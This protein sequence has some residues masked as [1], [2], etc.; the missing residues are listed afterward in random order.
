MAMSTK[1]IPVIW[2]L[3]EWWTPKDIEENLKMRNM[4]NMNVETVSNAMRHATR[5][6]FVC[7]AQKDLY[8]PAASSTVIFVG[9]PKPVR[10]QE[11]A[12]MSQHSVSFSEIQPFVFLYIGRKIRQ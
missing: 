10:L 4:S 1:K 12:L 7:A 8:Q 5:I 6:V 11:R 9:V 2:I 3:H